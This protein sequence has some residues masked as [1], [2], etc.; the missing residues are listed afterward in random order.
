MAKKYLS[1]LLSILI[2][3][4]TFSACS[5]KD[6][7]ELDTTV[8]ANSQAQTPIE[9]DPTSFK[10][11]YSQSDSLNPFESTTL[12]NQILQ[13]LV[14]ESLFKLNSNY[15][16]EPMLATGYAYTD[17]YTLIVTIPNGKLFS[18]NTKLSVN[19]IV[20]SFQ[21]AKSS[22]HWANALVNINSAKAISDSEVEFKLNYPQPLTQNLLTFAI[23]KSE[24]NDK[25]FYIGSGRYA[26][27]SSSTG[28]YLETNQNKKDFDP[29]FTKIPLVNIT[30]EESIQ[31]AVNIGNISWAYLDLASGEQS[32]MICGKKAVNLNNMVYIGLNSYS[33]ITANDY[34]RKAISL[35]IDR[36]LLVKSAYQ[37]RAYEA[38][39][40]F[41]PNSSFGK[42]TNIFNTEADVSAAK[43]AIMQSGY[44]SSALYLTILTNDNENRVAAAQLIKKQL[45]SVGF[46]VNVNI[47]PNDSYYSMLYYNNYDIYIGETKIPNDMSL[48]SFFTVNG[49]TNY[50]VNLDSNCVSSYYNY[51]NGT[52]Q[53]GKFVLDFAEDM[54]FIPLVYRQG[55]IC[56]SKS[57]SG[58]IQ[59]SYENYFANIQDW[60][61]NS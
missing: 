23:V 30:A 19:D 50:G 40:M 51:L 57:I 48:D 25:G 2:I 36:K 38:T 14:Y 37:S 54:P 27:N 22:V 39:S 7:N 34:I 45:E 15:D 55:L 16:V 43:Q 26:F 32:R 52:S 53:I 21:K 4:S 13:T 41:N 10:L 1:I 56:Y 8:I 49:A 59:G 28:V 47:Q 24:P 42:Q 44:N 33:S 29:T 11:S 17:D 3:A 35:A 12:N 5:V 61:Y 20:Y 31:N 60:H 6:K 18:D 46:R 58:D 9:K